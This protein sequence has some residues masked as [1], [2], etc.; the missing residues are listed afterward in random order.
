MK[1]ELKVLLAKVKAQ[2]GR[3]EPTKGGHIQ[4]KC[5]NP[6]TCNGTGIVT[7]AGTASDHRSLKNGTAQLRRCGFAV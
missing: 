5:P 6:A 2:G 1:K 7:L 4:V 3:V